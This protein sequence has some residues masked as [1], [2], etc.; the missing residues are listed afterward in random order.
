MTIVVQANAMTA[1]KKNRWRR[2]SAD[3]NACMLDQSPN[4]FGFK[5]RRSRAAF[6][7]LRP[8]FFGIPP[9]SEE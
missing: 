9:R 4:L 6:S 7:F 3:A 1:Q 8:G 2:E 5:L